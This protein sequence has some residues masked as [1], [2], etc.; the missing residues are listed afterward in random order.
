MLYVSQNVR[1]H[2]LSELIAGSVQTC[3]L[4]R[5]KVESTMYDKGTD[6]SGIS[7]RGLNLLSRSVPHD[8]HSQ[9]APM[10]PYNG[11]GTMS[12]RSKARSERRSGWAL[13]PQPRAEQHPSYLRFLI[14][15]Q[16]FEWLSTS[17]D[18]VRAE[19]VTVVDRRKRVRGVRRAGGPPPG[20]A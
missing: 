10:S 2:L 20:G 19:I 17:D 18:R 15:Q 3:A 5:L 9:K 6:H 11:R 4:Y 7:S 12:R 8:L 13:G 1:R 16:Q 14:R